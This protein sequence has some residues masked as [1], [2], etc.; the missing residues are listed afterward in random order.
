MKI[1]TTSAPCRLAFYCSSIAWGGLEMNTVRYALWMQELGHDV[2]IYCVDQSPIHRQAQKDALNSTLI[3]RNAKY[4]DFINSRRIA[5]LLRQDERQLVW[6]RDTRDMDV[7]NW[8]KRFFGLKI[9]FLYQQAM[10]F[11][12]SKKDIMHTLRYACIDA[13]VSTLPFLAA[14]VRTMTNFDASRLHVVPLGVTEPQ[15]SEKFPQHRAAFGLPSEGYIL[16]LMGRIDPLKGQNEAIEALHH[17]H[18]KGLQFHLLFVGDSTLHEGNAYREQLHE[19]IRAWALEPYV[20]FHGHLKDIAKFHAAIDCF[21]MCS[22]GET[23]GTVTIEAMAFSNPIIATDSAG[24]PEILDHGSCGMLY[25]PGDSHA[26]AVCIERLYRDPSRVQA[27]VE[28]AEQRF[29]A[30]YSKTKS[31]QR[32]EQIV[33]SLVKK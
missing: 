30:E 11:G 18:K 2:R 12:V 32:M 33:Q 28:R 4:F 23:F 31:V 21:L 22:K 25:P 24:S 8:A 6:F 20:H 3:R 1:N 14:Q 16:G 15:P 5:R 27:M 29:H 9:P 7:L 17:L 26:L 19:T 10:Q 13:W